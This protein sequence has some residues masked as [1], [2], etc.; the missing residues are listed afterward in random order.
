MARPRGAAAPVALAVT[1]TMRLG[2]PSRLGISHYVLD[3][4]SRFRAAVID[5]F[6][7]AYARGETPVPCIRCNQRIKF[8]DLLGM[9]RDLGASAL[10]TG[11]YVR[12]IAGPDG[13]ELH[14]AY[15]AARDQSYFLFATKREELE[16]LR[17]P[18]GGLTKDNSRRGAAFWPAD[19]R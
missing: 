8:R 19:R 14:R 3:Y 10:A 9:A 16:F 6:V 5:D 7:D 4:E 1:S 17:F 18:F 13:P 15:D 11:H 2:S 12:R